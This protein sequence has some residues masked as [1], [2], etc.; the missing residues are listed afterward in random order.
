MSKEVKG[1][2]SRSWSIEGEEKSVK[3][4]HGASESVGFEKFASRQRA[5]Y[6]KEKQA[7]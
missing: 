2:S 7:P 1:R 3:K 4:S 6:P 5:R